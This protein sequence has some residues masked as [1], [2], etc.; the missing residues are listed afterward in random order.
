[1]ESE[2]RATR[3]DEYLRY[4]V[5]SA[6]VGDIDP[7]YSMLRYVCDRFELNEEQ[8]YWLA[9]LYAMTY[10]GA[11]AFYA[12]CEFPDY[13]N[14]DVGRM[15]RW[16]DSRGRQEIIC[17]TDRRWVRSSSMF[18]PAFESYRAMITHGLAR[19]GEERDPSRTQHE[20]F[21]YFQDNWSTPELRYEALYDVCST[22]YSFGQFALFLYLEALHTVTPIRL[23]P[24][25]LDLDRA[26]SCR[27]GLY[28]AYGR[29]DLVRDA[30]T[31]IEPG[32]HELTG[33]M[34]ADL[35]RRLSELESPPTVWQTETLLCAY[36]KWHRGKR[37]VGYYLDRQASE[38]AKMSD[39]VRRGIWWE[40][41]W[42]YRE[43]TFP[44]DMLAERA[45]FDAVSE[46]GVSR[47]WV[48][49]Q[50]ERTDEL[51]RS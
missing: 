39:K 12:Y 48:E 20:F 42:Q 9:W 23:C 50:R 47:R 19:H 29:D 32:R 6:R 15:R 45:D 30:E 27:N 5:E 7:S 17:Q 43:E 14:V 38:I 25:D 34:W 33:Q 37:Y 18:V 1:M 10:C 2:Q 8:R 41:L 26:W 46:R 22:M 4:H 13:E 40:L 36:R 11:S 21:S 31:R 49:Q 24:T 51:V 28:Y 16:W 35:R 3:L 44:H